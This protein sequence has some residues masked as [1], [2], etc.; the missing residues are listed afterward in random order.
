MPAAAVL[1]KIKNLTMKR[2]RMTFRSSMFGSRFEV[3][4]NRAAGRATVATSAPMPFLQSMGTILKRE[5]RKPMVTTVRLTLRARPRGEIADDP[6]DM[7]EKFFFFFFFPFLS[8]VAGHYP[9]RRILLV[10][11]C[12]VNSSKLTLLS[13]P[14]AQSKKNFLRSAWIPWMFV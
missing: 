12:L 5:Q 2:Q 1:P 8:T 3:P 4:L 11:T 9:E 6:E 7:Q 13:L 14:P 10:S